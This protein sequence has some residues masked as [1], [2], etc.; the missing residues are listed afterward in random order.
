[1]DIEDKE[2]FFVTCDICASPDVKVCQSWAIQ[3]CHRQ[4][5]VINGRAL[6]HVQISELAAGVRVCSCLGARDGGDHRAS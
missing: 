4:T 5:S 2:I 1:M 3:K 6:G